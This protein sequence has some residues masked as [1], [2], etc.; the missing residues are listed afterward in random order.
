M[1]PFQSWISLCSLSQIESLIH[2]SLLLITK[3]RIRGLDA[4]I[5]AGL[6]VARGG[7]RRRKTPAARQGGG[8]SLPAL[9]ANVIPAQFLLGSGLGASWGDDGPD[10]GV[11]AGHRR[12]QRA[13]DGERRRADS[14]EAARMRERR[15]G[16]KDG[17][18]SVPY[19]SQSSWRRTRRGEAAERR[20]G[21]EPELGGSNGDAG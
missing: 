5:G 18:A 8:G 7:W 13:C 16:R 2:K 11:R 21:I 10:C 6:L 14:G 3:T 9:I 12:P 20:V 19:T 15:V 1:N 4:F 17:S